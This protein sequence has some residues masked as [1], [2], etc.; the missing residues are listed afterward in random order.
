MCENGK[1]C[2]KDQGCANNKKNQVITLDDSLIEYAKRR[3][4]EIMMETQGFIAYSPPP[5]L[6]KFYEIKGKKVG[7]IIS[8]MTTKEARGVFLY[9]PLSKHAESRFG[10]NIYTDDACLLMNKKATRCI[11]CSA[12][13]RNEYLIK[14]KCP[15]CDGRSEWGGKNPRE[16]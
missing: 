2:D 14:G 7:V 6:T 4:E 1:K 16:R 15:D 10:G 11:M 9:R 3:A 13:T 5:G 12:P 8:T